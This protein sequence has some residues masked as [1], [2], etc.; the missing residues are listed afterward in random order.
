MESTT[1]RYARGWTNNITEAP[2]IPRAVECPNRDTHAQRQRG[3]NEALL[4]GLEG[5]GRDRVVGLGRQQHG[6]DRVD[7]AVDHLDGISQQR[8]TPKV[9]TDVHL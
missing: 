4:D 1:A 7:G 9:V 2:F 3:P 6:V 5:E 8:D